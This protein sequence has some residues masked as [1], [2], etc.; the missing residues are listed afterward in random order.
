MYIKPVNAG[1]PS[2]E[3]GPV[4]R[5]ASAKPELQPG[6]S[7]PG[8]PVIQV[9]EI[10]LTPSSRSLLQLETKTNEPPIDE[11]K[12]ASLREA[13]ASGAYQINS[14]RIARKMIDLEESLFS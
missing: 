11:A 2:R 12:V 7:R 3:S 13:I 1:Y 10:Q 4:G 6:S 14:G 8:A 5:T 9:D